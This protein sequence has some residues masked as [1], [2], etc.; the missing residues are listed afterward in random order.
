[1][2]MPVGNFS[3]I[4]HGTN[5]LCQVSLLS[6]T[7]HV[8]AL[9]LQIEL[10]ITIANLVSHLHEHVYLN[11]FHAHQNL[12]KALF[13]LKLLKKCSFVLQHYDT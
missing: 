13:L 1:M 5:R 8:H 7:Y 12:S 10:P 11:S 9:D 4:M 2:D 3:L 6:F